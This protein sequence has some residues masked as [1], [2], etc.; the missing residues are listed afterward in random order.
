METFF[1]CLVDFIS[2]SE[3]KKEKRKSTIY[4]T[5]NSFLFAKYIWLLHSTEISW[6][7]QIFRLYKQIC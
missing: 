2:F 6:Y 5:R 7:I 4:P 1:A 3:R